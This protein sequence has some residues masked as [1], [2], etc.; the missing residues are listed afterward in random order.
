MLRSL[1]RR[2]F[3]RGSLISAGALAA[4]DF[5]YARNVPVVL[6]ARPQTVIV[7][8][9]GIAGLVAAFEL[10][11]TGHQVVVLEARKRAGGRIHT[12]RDE[13]ADGL[14]VEAGAVD[15]SSNYTL[16]LRYMKL[17]GV[18]TVVHPEFPK[19]V[20]YIGGRR[21][22]TPPD[23]RLG[24]S[25][26]ERKLGPDQIWNKYVVSEAAQAGDP[27]HPVWPA[28]LKRFLRAA[29]SILTRGWF[30]LRSKEPMSSLW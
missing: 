29:T 11:Q 21:Y 15:F 20:I 12:L 10:M 16:L 8:G 13:F 5:N 1:D 6:A 14:F 30:W 19:S 9:A 4:R 24:L 18:P 25:E 2:T 27:R 26:E 17:L 28:R 7:V 3:L 22:V 23:P